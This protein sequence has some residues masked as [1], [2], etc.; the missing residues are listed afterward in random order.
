MKRCRRGIAP[1]SRRFSSS[2]VQGSR[3]F[4]LSTDWLSSSTTIRADL[5]APLHS[6]ACAA[7][8]S[9]ATSVGGHILMHCRDEP[10][11]DNAAFAHQVPLGQRLLRLKSIRAAV[12]GIFALSQAER[13][14]LVL[15]FEHDIAFDHHID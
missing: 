12:D 3:A 1:R 5:L 7:D 15:A 9:L 8:L 4:A 10:F 14:Q 2:S 6:P 13:E 11:F